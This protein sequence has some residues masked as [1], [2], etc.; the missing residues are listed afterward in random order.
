MVEPPLQI[1]E[2]APRDRLGR[3]VQM[4]E[5]VLRGL[6]EADQPRTAIDAY[7]I[8]VCTQLRW[9]AAVAY[10]VDPGSLRMLTPTHEAF[11]DTEKLGEAIRIVSVR[12]PAKNRKGLGARVLDTGEP[13]W[14]RDLV[15]S[16]TF[17]A[18][19]HAEIL[20]LRGAIA[21]PV[22]VGNRLSMVIE[23]FT[24]QLFEPDA[25]T[26]WSLSYLMGR[27]GERIQELNGAKAA[28]GQGS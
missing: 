22:Y 21:I 16:P 2:T 23:F 20:G 6:R 28:A 17:T 1:I 26:L 9:P 7:L 14:I 25:A 5:H 4:R 27:V 8:G 15:H 10:V 24:R 3:L 12:A 13:A 19:P 18:A 11:L